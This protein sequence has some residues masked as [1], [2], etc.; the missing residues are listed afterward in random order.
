MKFL[1]MFI[2][3]RVFTALDPRSGFRDNIEFSVF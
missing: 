3:Y 2:L 1:Y